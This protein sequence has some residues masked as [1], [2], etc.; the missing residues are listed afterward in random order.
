MSNMW[1]YIKGSE[2]D[3]VGAP[4]WAMV[5]VRF[6]DDA[7]IDFAESYENGSRV[8]YT[9]KGS[10]TLITD[11][12]CWTLVA[13]RERV[14]DG[15]GNLAEHMARKAVAVATLEGKGYTWCGDSAEWKSP[16]YITDDTVNHPSHYTQG[17]VECI[18]AIQA[19]T[20]GKT[21]IEA[22]CVANIIKYLWRYELKNGVQDIE[23][24]Q[25]YL[26]KLL[27]V[28]R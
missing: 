16:A 1:R 9:I 6:D 28:K 17:G 27:E 5:A 15:L 12:S 13:Q 23:K 7:E 2:S 22:A 25:W 4:D 8:W 18:D 19:A 26:N 3:F 14:T 20:V 21:G 11:L 24:A 10:E